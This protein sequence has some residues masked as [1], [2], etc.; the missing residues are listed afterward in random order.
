M[1]KDD[2]QTIHDEIINYL[3]VEHKT[4]FVNIVGHLR[5]KLGNDVGHNE[6]YV[7]IVMEELHLL[8]LN[9][10]VMIGNN[11]SQ[12]EHPWIWVTDYGIK[13][14]TEGAPVSL[15]PDGYITMIRQEIPQIDSVILD[16]LRE[17][18]SAFHRGLLLSSTITLGVASEQAM[19]LLIEA[20]AEFCQ[21]LKVKERLQGDVSL[22]TKYKILK[23]AISQ[24]PKNIKDKFPEN[25]DVHI[26]TLFNFIRLNRNETGH[27][28]GGGKDKNIQAA[29]LQAFKSYLKD[30]YSLTKIF[31]E[32]TK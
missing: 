5:E 7:K 12:W 13:C 30:I 22:F 29:N 6:Q 3:K 9:N 15:D 19:L 14:L 2:R 24:L 18:I 25:Y 32:E 10:I 8:L 20:F 23:E 28:L 31:Q 21:T 27:P 17:S 16:Y 4:Q 1:Y 11:A 26:D